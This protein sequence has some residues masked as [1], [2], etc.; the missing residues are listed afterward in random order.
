MV[1]TAYIG[2]PAGQIHISRYHIFGGFTISESIDRFCRVFREATR[3]SGKE[4]EAEV[5]DRKQ[6]LIF[7]FEELLEGS[8]DEKLYDATSGYTTHSPT[9]I[10]INRCSYHLVSLPFKQSTNVSSSS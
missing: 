5:A 9:H 2:H 8:D 7:Q 3:W 1:V 6:E 10:I 4:S